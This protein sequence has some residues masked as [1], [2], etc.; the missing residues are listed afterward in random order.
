MVHGVGA[1]ADDYAVHA[2]LDLLP[3]LLGGV[4][5]LLRT[6]VLGKDTI[7][8]F[9]FEIANIS[10]LRHRA[11]KLARGEGRYNRAGAIIKT[12]GDSPARAQQGNVG[13]G[14]IFGKFRLGNFVVRFFVTDLPYILDVLRQ[15]ADIVTV[16]HLQNQVTV[17][18]SLRTRQDYTCK[19]SFGRFDLDIRPDIDIEIL[20]NRKRRAA[21]AL[22]FIISHISP[23]QNYL[24]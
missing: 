9:G 5:I 23:R 12:R 7:K 17:V 13:L 1:M 18:G 22:V 10:Q 4:H 2:V 3:D 16:G 11:V 21:V 20:Q 6:H 15:H 19:N 8:F 14:R 24:Q